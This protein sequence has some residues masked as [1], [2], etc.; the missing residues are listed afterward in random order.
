TDKIVDIPY[1]QVGYLRY[2]D[3]QPVDDAGNSLTTQDEIE[4][5]IHWQSEEEYKAQETW[6]YGLKKDSDYKLF[7]R[8]IPTAAYDQSA[9]S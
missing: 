4:A 1:V 7:A 5:N 9:V 6:F 2:V 8:F 3:G